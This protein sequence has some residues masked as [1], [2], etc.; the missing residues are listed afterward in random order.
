M[1]ADFRYIV[2]EWIHV[3]RQFYIRNNEHDDYDKYIYQ[4]KKIRNTREVVFVIA[5][6]FSYNVKNVNE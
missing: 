1:S 5:V 3:D 6:F 4:S 2:I